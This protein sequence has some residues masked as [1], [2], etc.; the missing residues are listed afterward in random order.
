MELFTCLT[1]YINANISTFSD[2][3]LSLHICTHRGKFSFSLHSLKSKQLLA[4]VHYE[5]HS[6]AES[7][8]FIL[9]QIYEQEELLSF[10]Y[11]KISYSVED[12]K[13]SLIPTRFYTKESAESYLKLLYPLSEQEVLFKE[14]LTK[15]KAY[16]ISAISLSYQKALETHFPKATF[17]SIYKKLIDN[18]QILIK[19]KKQVVHQAFIHL[20]KNHFDILVFEYNELRFINTYPCRSNNDLL[21]FSLLL[22][23]KLKIDLGALHLYL[24]G[25]VE[26]IN[27]LE[28][29]ENQVLNIEYCQAPPTKHISE[30][31]NFSTYFT[32]IDL[33]E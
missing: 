26:G 8:N 16:C 9:S 17:V 18:G 3:Q 6:L 24:S 11:G 12:F 5:I 33:A 14:E 10:D 13:S 7:F 23:N 15:T 29:L 31:V 27:A 20:R 19:S 21:Y 28:I 22:L 32:L 1:R 25:Y 4:L 30:N 2:N